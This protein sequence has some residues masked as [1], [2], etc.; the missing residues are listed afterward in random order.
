MKKIKELSIKEEQEIQLSILKKFNK[1]C[2]N[3]NIEYLLAYGTLLGAVR[4]HGF[5]EWDDDVDIW[6]RRS[7]FKKIHDSFGKYFDSSKYFL[8][9][10]NTDPLNF[11]PEMLRICVN[12]TYKW[13][14]GCENDKFHSGIYFDIFPLD[15]GYGD[16]RDTRLLDDMTKYHTLL[17]NHMGASKVSKGFLRDVY[18]TAK[19]VMFPFGKCKKKILEISAI[20]AK[21]PESDILISLPAS[22][23]G[24][25]RSIFKHE[26]LKD[27]I[28]LQFEDMNLPCPKNYD[29]LLKYMYGEDYMIPSQTKPSYTKAY[30]VDNQ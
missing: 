24:T 19:R 27:V 18:H 9:D 2:Q 8:Q 25:K 29:A 3:E 5:I 10:A 26:M 23:A 22:F 20:Y 4:E 14:D 28:Y 13:P 16:E 12:G 30:F 1:M 7:D 21:L 15:N 17:R 6:V 11:S